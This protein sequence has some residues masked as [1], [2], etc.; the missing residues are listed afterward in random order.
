LAA[1]S[2]VVIIVTI[3]DDAVFKVYFDTYTGLNSIVYGFTLICGLASLGLLLRSSFLAVDADIKRQTRIILWGMALGILPFLALTLLPL[4]FGVSY[5]FGEY[6]SLF[7]VLIPLS[8]A[9]VINQRKLLKVDFIINRLVVFF[10]MGLVVLIA[11][12]LTL[13]L[14]STVLNLPSS[15]PIA[16]SIM[17]VIVALPSAG[18]RDWAN[19][20]VSRTLYGSYYDHASVA[21]SLSSRLAQ[22]LDRST[23]VYLLTE[24]LAKQMGIQKTALFLLN[25]DYLRQ[26]IGDDGFTISL[27]DELCKFLLEA[28]APVR[29]H[30]LRDLLSDDSQRKWQEYSWG[31]LIAPLIFERQLQGILILGGRT[32]G[33]IYSDQDMKIIA[34]VAHQGALAASN[35]QLVEI[36]RGLTQQLVRAGEEE[37]KQV[38][39]E[40]HDG[41]MQNL[42]FIKEIVRQ[43]PE[44]AGHLGDVITT[45]RRIIKTQRPMNLDLGLLPALEDLV[46]NMRTMV[47]KDG[48]QI[49]WS[50]SGENIYLPDDAATAIYRIAQESITNAIRH[51]HSQRI[52]VSLARDSSALVLKIDDDGIGM[53][54]HLAVDGQYGLTSMRER[55]NMIGA[56]LNIRS[57]KREG[58]KVVM[59]YKLC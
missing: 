21:G 44:A 31:E 40:L 19:R 6:T 15:V 33:D 54:E 10:V 18:L 41:V 42:L 39:R 7:L 25:G 49:E 1:T 20:W 57:K 11:S 59:E 24:D 36:R 16:G 50:S 13:V 14:F 17:A 12:F 55:A 51:A 47:G 26:Q 9:Y 30:N 48:P 35:V 37:R 56:N 5:I 43:N 46:S 53:P 34:S 45:L 4:L 32:A 8:Y 3:V 23:L 29:A 52:L 38:V 58:T 2:V 27:D 22:A 28:Q